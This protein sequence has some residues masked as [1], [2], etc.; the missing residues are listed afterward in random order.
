MYCNSTDA[1]NVDSKSCI[2]ILTHICRYI[3]I[4]Q[5]Y[6]QLHK[7]GLNKPKMLT[8]IYQ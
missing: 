7:K 5:I 4:K 6:L 1:K 2:I 3:H 8:V